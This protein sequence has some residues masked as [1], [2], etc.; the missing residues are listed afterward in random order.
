MATV[1]HT[2]QMSLESALYIV[3]IVLIF[4]LFQRNRNTLGRLLPLPALVHL[5]FGL[6]I[7]PV[8]GKTT[9]DFGFYT[10][11]LAFF[12]VAS[13]LMFRIKIFSVVTALAALGCAAIVALTNLMSL[14]G[15]LT[16]GFSG[17]LSSLYAVLAF[18]FYILAIVTALR[19]L[20]GKK[21]EN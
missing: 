15:Y 18:V 17:I 8:F 9:A 7:L 1:L 12:M 14:L 21:P 3:L 10:A 20:F 6:V 5:L 19:N 4:P 13:F 16:D 2:I 11:F